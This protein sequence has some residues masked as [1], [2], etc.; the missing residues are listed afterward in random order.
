MSEPDDFPVPTR[1]DHLPSFLLTQ[2]AMRVH[3]VVF[4]R[5]DAAGARGHHYRMLSALDEFGSSS[6]VELGRRCGLDRSDVVAC[7]DALA[8]RMYVRRAP[9]PQDRRR[10]IVSLTR[11]GRDRLAELERVLTAVQDEAFAPLDDGEREQLVA[12]LTKIIAH[13]TRASERRS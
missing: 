4:G 5:L 9:D 13:H 1:L 10:N 6:Q 2:S 3:R 7:I 11:K 12:M 8:D